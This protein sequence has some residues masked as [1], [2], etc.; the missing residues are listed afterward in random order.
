MEWVVSID[1]DTPLGDKALMMLGLFSSSFWIFHH[2]IEQ[3]PRISYPFSPDVTEQVMQP[4][5]TCQ[6]RCQ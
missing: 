3:Q 5:R 4:I 6:Q 1:S 2:P